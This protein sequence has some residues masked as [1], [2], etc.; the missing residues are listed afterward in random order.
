[1]TAILIY[2]LLYF[3]VV[4]FRSG[5]ISASEK[6]RYEDVKSLILVVFCF[7]NFL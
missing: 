5:F 4:R 6:E 2:S 7:F 1:M 3:Q